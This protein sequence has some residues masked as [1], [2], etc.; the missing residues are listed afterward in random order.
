ML[1]LERACM[2]IISL[3]DTSLVSTCMHIATWE[4]DDNDK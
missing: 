2:Y 4:I 3:A 1:R